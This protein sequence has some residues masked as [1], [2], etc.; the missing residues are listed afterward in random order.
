MLR[1]AKTF[2]EFL[3]AFQISTPTYKPKDDSGCKVFF[4]YL[5]KN[6]SPE[7][8]RNELTSLGYAVR[9][10]NAVIN[11]A[12][13]EAYNGFALHLD[14]LTNSKEICNVGKLGYQKV[15]IEPQRPPL[16]QCQ[17]CQKFGHSKRQCSSPFACV[18]CAGKHPTHDCKK[19]TS[20]E[21]KC[22][23][24]SG[25][26][27]AS[28]K[29]CSEYLAA[30]SQHKMI[31]QLSPPPKAQAYTCTDLEIDDE[32]THEGASSSSTRTPYD[33]NRMSIKKLTETIQTIQTLHSNLLNIQNSIC[34]RQCYEQNCA[35]CCPSTTLSKR[36][37]SC[38]ALTS[39]KHLSTLSSTGEYLSWK[40]LRRLAT[41]IQDTIDEIKRAE[42][43]SK[44]ALSTPVSVHIN[45]LQMLVREFMPLSIK[46]NIIC[47]K[48]CSDNNYW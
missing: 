36:R 2:T 13:G 26:H 4:R 43:S 8:I 38:S 48:D 30:L 10:V 7:W 40:Q 3:S 27:T 12:T 11:R 33:D 24:C 1:P 44:L 42:R 21:P 20:E 17:R 29:G 25:A 19:S 34:T 28:Y 32:D 35:N 6:T 47:D 45:Q 9:S 37:P 16:L 41:E 5:N 23:N 31:A 22:A 46:L 39:S 15:I 14:A 18:K